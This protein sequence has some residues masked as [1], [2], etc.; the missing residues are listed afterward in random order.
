MKTTRA[1]IGSPRDP[2]VFP[3]DQLLIA[4]EGIS[5][6]TYL[7]SIFSVS[8][9]ERLTIGRLTVEV[10]EAVNLPVAD[11]GGSSDP[12]VNLELS[13]RFG[14]GPKNQREWVPELRTSARTHYESSTLNPVW[15]VKGIPFQLKRHGAVLKVRVFDHDDL[16][17]DDPLGHVVIYLNHM[18]PGE[19]DRWWPLCDP[20]EP[21]TLST[22]SSFDPD[23]SSAKTISG[24]AIRLR[25]NFK[26]DPF[27]ELVSYLWSPP[28]I[29]KP[30][31]P[32]FD[33]NLFFSYMTIIKNK[34]INSIS[35]CITAVTDAISWKRG[36]SYTFAVLGFALTVCEHIDS[37]WIILHA[38]LA[39][40]IAGTGIM[41]KC[42]SEPLLSSSLTI[43]P[44]HST[45][46]GDGLATVP[47]SPLVDAKK[48]KPNSRL[49]IKRPSS[50]S[51]PPIDVAAEEAH[52]ELENSPHEVEKSKRFTGMVEITL[53][54]VGRSFGSGLASTQEA[55]RQATDVLAMLEGLILWERRDFKLGFGLL[56]GPVMATGFALGNLILAAIHCFV[57]L[58][59]LA[60]MAVLVMFFSSIFGHLSKLLPQGL[61]VRKARENMLLAEDI[62]KERPA[63]INKTSIQGFAQILS[64]IFRRVDIDGKAHARRRLQ[65]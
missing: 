9:Q 19:H 37:F 46:D 5:R 63:P 64:G 10:V 18:A 8:L 21:Q 12:Y 3:P 17:T 45:L 40:T 50:M 23:A 47:D 32:Q 56:D 61:K 14:T 55:L 15:N 6:R 39:V 58:K 53:R 35:Y 60:T 54:K 31:P 11:F 49:I 65:S 43:E 20:Q 29:V 44:S 27:G 52:I 4:H 51:S 2:E 38:I 34:G 7:K 62:L 24:P 36:P 48:K 59:Y 30:T 28:K 25:I 13:G 26:I 42:G 57:P 16:A 41:T 33:P 22:L 1:N